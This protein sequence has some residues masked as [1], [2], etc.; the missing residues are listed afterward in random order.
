M[1]ANAIIESLTTKVKAILQNHE[2][3]LEQPLTGEN[4]ENVAR[5]L[6]EALAADRRAG[7]TD[8]SLAIEVRPLGAVLASH[9][10]HPNHP[11]PQNRRLKS[12]LHP[13]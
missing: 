6:A 9:E 12:R 4:A 7:D 11:S 5:I 13:N 10:K 3:G 2:V 1:K 8:A